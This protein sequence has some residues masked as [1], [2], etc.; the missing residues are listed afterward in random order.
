MIVN[1]NGADRRKFETC[2]TRACLRIVRCNINIG[3]RL[4]PWLECF[5]NHATNNL[6]WVFGDPTRLNFNFIQAHS[7]FFSRMSDYPSVFYSLFSIIFAIWAK[8]AFTIA[9]DSPLIMC[10]LNA[11]RFIRSMYD[12]I[13]ATFLRIYVSRQRKFQLFYDLSMS[14]ALLGLNGQDLLFGPT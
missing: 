6:H 3:S 13:A 11:L 10:T 8:N 12:F 7:V 1:N 4:G 9:P 14:S 5:A 2:T